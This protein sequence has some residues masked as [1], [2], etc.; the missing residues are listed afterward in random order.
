MLWSLVGQQPP[1]P[2]AGQDFIYFLLNQ[3]P[4]IALALG[5]LFLLVKGYI[6]TPQE[7]AAITAACATYKEYVDKLVPGVQELARTFASYMT[8]QAHEQEESKL[9][10]QEVLHQLQDLNGKWVEPRE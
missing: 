8:A 6:R 4:S 7:V 3:A 9:K 10:M 2:P 1:T 5:L